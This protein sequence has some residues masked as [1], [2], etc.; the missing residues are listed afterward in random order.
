MRT[1]STKI[2]RRKTGNLPLHRKLLATII[3]YNNLNTISISNFLLPTSFFAYLSLC[4]VSGDI[5]YQ[6]RHIP[7]PVSVLLKLIYSLIFET[8]PAPTVLPPSLMAKR[9]P[10]SIAIGVINFILIV[11]LSPG[12][13]ISTPSGSDMLPVTSVVL[14]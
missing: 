7:R 10:S 1:Y 4:N 6:L 12:M 5:P 2:P 11:I 13:H 3:V 8:T 14:K 9:R